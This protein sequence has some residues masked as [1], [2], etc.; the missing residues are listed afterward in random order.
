MNFK[1]RLRSIELPFIIAY[2]TL[3]ILIY[4]SSRIVLEMAVDEKQSTMLI[5]AAIASFPLVIYGTLRA[6]FADKSKWH[7]F[8]G[9]YLMFS[10]FGIFMT[11]YMLIQGKLLY[12][13]A[14]QNEVQRRV[15][16]KEVKR[17]FSRRSG[18]NHTAVTFILDGKPI[19]MKARAYAYFYLQDKKM[20]DI[21]FGRSDMGDYVT[22]IALSSGDKAHARWLHLKDF[23]YRLKYIGLIIL[24]MIIGG[25]IKARYFPAQPGK[26]PQKMGLWK[27][28]AI[29]MAIL[30][31]IVILLYIGLWVYVTFIANY[32]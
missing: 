14:V 30:I 26:P 20:I 1:D 31:T 9:Y 18:S 8:I 7:G 15:Q 2:F 4:L 21:N 13:V 17:V 28:T 25:L 29:I 19:T 24:A 27:M 22:N 5:W 12:D 32:R 16:I 10:L 11:Q 6:G 23:V 3:W